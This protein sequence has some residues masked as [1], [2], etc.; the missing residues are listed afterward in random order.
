MNNLRKASNDAV[1]TYAT[2]HFMNIILT[3]LLVSPSGMVETPRLEAKQDFP[4]S[5]KGTREKHPPTEVGGF[6]TSAG[7]F[8]PAA[9]A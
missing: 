6:E 1:F 4:K 9:H 8:P 3:Y 7:I 5:P 2:A